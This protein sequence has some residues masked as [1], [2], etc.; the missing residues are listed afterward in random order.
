MIPLRDNVPGERFPLIMWTIIILN[1]LVF[2]HELGLPHDQ[3]ENLFYTYG[4]IPARLNLT[5]IFS[6]MF[7]HGG[8]MHIIGN[9][10]AL[11]LFGNNVEDRMGPLRF[12]L[13]YLLCGIVAALTH[14]FVYPGSTIPTVGASGA[15]AGVMGAY[16]LLFPRARVLTLIPVFVFFYFVELP[17]VIY[18]GFWALSQLASGTMALFAAEGASQIAFWAHIGG[19]AAGMLLHR[20]FLRPREN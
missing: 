8:W 16:L 20:F 11:F 9:M 18:L 5:T 7:L 13:F 15:L 2:F 1:A 17:A 12:L 6:S 4:L 19:F 14:Y 10:W 3:L